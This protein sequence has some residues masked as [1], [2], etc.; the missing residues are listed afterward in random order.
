MGTVGYALN[1]LK[2]LLGLDIQMEVFEVEIDE[3]AR[4]VAASV[5]GKESEQLQPHDLWEW[6]VDEERTLHWLRDKGEIDQGSHNRTGHL[7][8]DFVRTFRLKAG[9][10]SETPRK[11]RAGAEARAGPRTAGGG[12]VQIALQ[13][14]TPLYHRGK[15]AV[16]RTSRIGSIVLT[17]K[18]ADR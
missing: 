1:K 10:L 2:R 14:R 8:R 7:H 15:Y 4:A 6:A 17:K 3:I 16:R 11:R 13:R 12:P 9:P 5:G 18:G